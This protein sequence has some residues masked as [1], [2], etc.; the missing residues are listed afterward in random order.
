VEE[1]DIQL[2]FN[3]LNASAQSRLA[4]A[5]SRRGPRVVQFLRQ[6]YNGGQ[7]TNLKYVPQGRPLF[8]MYPCL[9]EAPRLKFAGVQDGQSSNYPK[10]PLRVD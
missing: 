10:F 2:E 5:E 9:K 3:I 6:D 7:V 4:H 8:Q 1:H